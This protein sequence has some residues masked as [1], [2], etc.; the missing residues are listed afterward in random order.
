[1]T[2][3][4]TIK[5]T[6]QH[7][8]RDQNPFRITPAGYVMLTSLATAMMGALFG[9]ILQAMNHAETAYQLASRV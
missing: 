8:A 9:L 6:G 1:M 7:L 2:T 4:N 3:P 5:M